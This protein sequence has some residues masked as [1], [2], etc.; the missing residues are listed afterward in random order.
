MSEWEL[1]LDGPKY[2]V[3]NFDYGVYIL[4]LL[5]VLLRI[6]SPCVVAIASQ[7]VIIL[8]SRL[9]WWYSMKTQAQTQTRNDRQ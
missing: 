5:H 1:T 3:L 2:E 9:E 7:R 6:E 4:L 8:V